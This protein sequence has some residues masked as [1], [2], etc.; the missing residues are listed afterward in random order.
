MYKELETYLS[1]VQNGSFS[2]AAKELYISPSAVFQQINNLENHLG[3]KLLIRTS[4]G[5]KVTEA[6]MILVRRG[7]E[8]LNLCKQTQSELKYFKKQITLGAGFL[9]Q[10][11][12][13]QKLIKGSQIN[14]SISFAEVKD[15]NSISDTVDLL[16]TIYTPGLAKQGFSFQKISE[17]PLAIAIAPN[18]KLKSKKRISE[19]D[20][21]NY[22]I[23]V[24]K[25]GL[26]SSTDEAVKYLKTNKHLKIIE[27]S[28]YNHSFI[29]FCQLN[30][31]LMLVPKCWKKSCEPYILKDLDKKFL[32]DYGYFYR[33]NKIKILDELMMTLE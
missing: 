20:L 28:Q 31:T 27:L 26:S 12:E 1:V 13:F 8:I 25:H 9:T 23:T 19:Q 17:I 4:H 18:C 7:Q 22:T 21:S 32:L 30:N 14:V 2:K 16:E 6:G 3:V 10:N 5:V 33:K 11:L 29:D 24:I 15:Y